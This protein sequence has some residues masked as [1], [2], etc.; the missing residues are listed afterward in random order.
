MSHDYD[1]DTDVLRVMAARARR[2]VAELGS[3]QVAGPVDVGHEWVASAAA[4]FGAAW[5]AGLSARVADTEDFADRL[6]TT[7][8]VFDEGTDAARAEI[9]AMIWDS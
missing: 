3:L 2:A 5:S 8:R 6:G 9:D 1:I 7:A 4:G